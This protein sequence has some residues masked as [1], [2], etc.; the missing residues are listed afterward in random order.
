[1]SCLPGFEGPGLPAT[2]RRPG[3]SRPGAGRAAAR[4]PGAREAFQQEMAETVQQ[5]TEVDRRAVVAGRSRSEVDRPA[6]QAI[7]GP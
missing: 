7:P 2:A 6:D 5:R 3:S 4:E 1:M